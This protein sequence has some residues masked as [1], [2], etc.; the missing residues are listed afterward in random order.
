[1]TATGHRFERW[2]LVLAPNIH[3]DGSRIASRTGSH[4]DFDNDGPTFWATLARVLDIKDAEATFGE[5]RL[6]SVATN[7]ERRAVLAASGQAEAIT[8]T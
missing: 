2:N 1:M 7:P 8:A 4:G 6:H 5:G 3:P